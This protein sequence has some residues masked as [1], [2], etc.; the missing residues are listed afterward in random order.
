MIERRGNKRTGADEENGDSWIITGNRCGEVG[1]WQE[2]NWTQRKQ[3]INTNNKSQK[4]NK[5]TQSTETGKTKSVHLKTQHP[6]SSQVLITAPLTP[7][8]VEEFWPTPPSSVGLCWRSHH[9]VSVSLGPGLCWTTATPW[10]FLIRSVEDRLL[11]LGSLSYWTSPVQASAVRQ[12][13][14]F[15]FFSFYQTGVITKPK[16]PWGTRTKLWGQTSQVRPSGLERVHD[17]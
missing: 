1:R 7:V 8:V 9:S 16:K 10:F 12:T 3:T 17:V 6:G 5:E 11:C 2:T 13:L 4:I 15:F 14:T